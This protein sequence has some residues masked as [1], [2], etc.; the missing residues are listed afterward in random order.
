[1]TISVD[2]RAKNEMYEYGSHEKNLIL[3]YNISFEPATM[4]RGSDLPAVTVSALGIPRNQNKIPASRM[5]A[6]PGLTR[7]SH[8]L[9][10][11][12]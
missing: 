7:L 10:T 12:D 5:F 8:Y 6:F 4:R 3:F 2:E 1:M 11:C 9:A